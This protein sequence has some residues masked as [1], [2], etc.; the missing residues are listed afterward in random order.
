MQKHLAAVIFDMDGLLFDSES[1]YRDAILA[2][3]TELDHNFTANDFVKLIG[4]PWEVNRVTIQDHIGAARSLDEFRN[5]WMRHYEAMRPR[6]A[7]KAGVIEILEQLDKLSLPR[8]ICTSSSRGTVI[9]NLSLHSLVGRFD[10]IVASGDYARGK[11]APDPYL[12]AAEVLGVAPEN[13]L[14]LEDSHAGIRSAS[15]AGMQVI[16]VP[17]LIIPTSE[18]QSLCNLVANTLHEVLDYLPVALS[19]KS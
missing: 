8:A 10:A 19:Q 1:L 3:A 14:A 9:Q 13:C 15:F 7:L 5:A 6:L 17:D 4:N 18:I 11:P 2:A 12:K 16:M